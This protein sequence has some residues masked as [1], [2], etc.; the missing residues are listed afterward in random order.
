MVVSQLPGKSHPLHPRAGE[1]A[2]V[3]FVGHQQQHLVP[4]LAERGVTTTVSALHSMSHNRELALFSGADRPLGLALDP[5]THRRQLPASDRGKAY[6]AQQ[7]G[8]GPA[9]DP[10]RES[11]SSRFRKYATLP[12][13]FSR[14]GAGRLRIPIIKELM[15]QTA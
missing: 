10:D 14:R 1:G 5:M 15:S 8:D 12:V 6:R 4:V 13:S 7:H 11:L 2:F 3:P 9:F